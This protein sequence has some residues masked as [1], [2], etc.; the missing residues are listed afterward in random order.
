MPNRLLAT[1]DTHLPRLE[2]DPAQVRNA[3]PTAELLQLA[4][5]GFACGLWEHTAGS[6]TDVEVDEVFVVL[7]GRASIDIAGEVSI[8][9]GPGDVVQLEAGTRTTW[10]IHEDLRKFWITRS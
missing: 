2:L 9:V 3:T 10:R 8:D 4:D 1:S 5:S 6:S 7:S